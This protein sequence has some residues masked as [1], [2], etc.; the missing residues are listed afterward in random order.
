MRYKLIVFA[1][2]PGVGKS[3][4]AERFAKKINAPHLNTD[5]IRKEL[6]GVASKAPMV[7]AWEGGIYSRDMSKA[8]YEEMFARA[9]K[10]LSEGNCVLD[11]TFMRHEFVE[12]A[13]SVAKEA[14]V[15]F[16]L[17]ECVCPERIVFERLK[18]KRVGESVSDATVE[19]YMKVKNHFEPF[20]LPDANYIKVNASQPVD[21]SIKLIVEKLS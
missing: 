14:N 6:A 9:Q 12:G 19:V 3:Y 10:A 17:V 11:G 1:G 4:L 7:A 8:T 20:E 5:V 16:L 2:L 18:S 13:L 21:R 15:R